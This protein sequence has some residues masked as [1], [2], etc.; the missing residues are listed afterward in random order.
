MCGRETS[1]GLYLGET[2]STSSTAATPTALPQ[3]RAVAGATEGALLTDGDP[4]LEDIELEPLHAGREQAGGEQVGRVAGGD[5]PGPDPDPRS[6]VSRSFRPAARPRMRV[7]ASA[8][9]PC[10]TAS[11]RAVPTTSP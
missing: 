2:S 7:M 5:R 4:V 10:S 11:R 9:D 3:S 1:V 8:I 6:L